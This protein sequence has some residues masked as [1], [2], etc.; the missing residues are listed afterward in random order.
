MSN[1]R[2]CMLTTAKALLRLSV[3][4][5]GA[6]RGEV[7][8]R[9]LELQGGSAGMP[10]CSAFYAFCFELAHDMTASVKPW[11]P[12]LST[13]ENYRLGKKAGKITTD[14]QGGDA[15][16]FRDAASPTGFR[17]TAMFGGWVDEAHG[18]YHTIEGNVGDAVQAKQHTTA[19]SVVFVSCE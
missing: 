5:H 18:V 13:S 2:L 11:N 4:E 8:S 3:R 17:H 12:G 1:V 14:P 15:V 6:N 19:E 16:L 7:V 9:L 10:W